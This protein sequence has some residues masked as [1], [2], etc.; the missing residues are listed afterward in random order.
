MRPPA[1][2]TLC[3]PIQCDPRRGDVGRLHADTR[4]IRAQRKTNGLGDMFA[5]FILV[6]SGHPPQTTR[7]KTEKNDVSITHEGIDTTYIDC[8]QTGILPGQYS[9][10]S[11][12]PLHTDMIPGTATV[13]GIVNIEW[14]RNDC[15][16]SEKTLELRV[17]PPL[18]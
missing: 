17:L 8:A 15:T 16:Y 2:P 3:R 13:E 18:G 7:A 5:R 11:K 1:W 14:R 9:W 6:C 12:D 10:H 4:P